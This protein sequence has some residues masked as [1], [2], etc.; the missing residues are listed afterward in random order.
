MGDESLGIFSPIHPQSAP[1]AMGSVQNNNNLNL[2]MIRPIVIVENVTHSVLVQ[3]QEQAQLLWQMINAPILSYELIPDLTSMLTMSQQQIVVM[4]SDGNASESVVVTALQVN[5]VCNAVLE[6]AQCIANGTK[7]RYQEEVDVKELLK[8]ADSDKKEDDELSLEHSISLEKE[9]DKFALNAPS[10]SNK[11]KS[12]KK[13]HSKVKEKGKDIDLL[14]ID[15][16]NINGKKEENQNNQEK[17]ENILDFLGVADSQNNNNQNQQNQPKGTEPMIFDPLNMLE[18][19][20]KNLSKEQTFTKQPKQQ[21][22][23]N[24]NA[25]K[26]DTFDTGSDPFADFGGNAFDE[27]PEK[28][29]ENIPNDPFAD[30]G[31]NAFDDPIMT[32]TAKQKQPEIKQNVIKN[33]NLSSTPK[34]DSNPFDALS[35][36]FGTNDNLQDNNDKNKD[37]ENPFD[38][39]DDPF[40]AEKNGGDQ[41]ENPFDGTLEN[42]F[43]DKE[44]FMAERDPFE[45]M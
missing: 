41:A 40:G 10:N 32:E 21:Y 42:P 11:D 28:K 31:G 8:R 30:F 17:E 39:L 33:N 20:N 16:M 12:A 34:D 38:S 27:I 4:I 3:A 1:T 13:R 44:E 37:N 15:D 45:D 25:P 22:N 19:E 6:D 43:K 29:K 18:T 23:L 36:P 24:G 14:G 9:Q 7:R 35:N 26:N 5:D 2:P